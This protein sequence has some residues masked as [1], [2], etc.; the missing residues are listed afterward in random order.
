M[1]NWPAPEAWSRLYPGMQGQ[2]RVRLKGVATPDHPDDNCL[3]FVRSW[4]AESAR[5]LSGL[6]RALLLLPADRQGRHAELEAR[7]GVIYHEDPR[8]L[9]ACIAGRFF[10][11]QAHRG[12][13]RLQPESGVIMAEDVHVDPT[14]R[15]EPGVTICRG[16]RIGP[17]A[18]VLSG[19]RLGPEVTIGR[20]SVVRENAVLGG[21]GFGYAL[22][23]GRP[24]MRLPHLGGVILG[25]QVEVG[26][27]TTVCSGTIEPTRIEDRVK[28]DDH[29][30]IAHNC[31][32]QPDVMVTACAELS[33][34]VRVGGRSWLGPNCSV[35]NKI[36]IGPDC[37]IGL[38]AV[39]TE[40]VPERAT[41]TGNPARPLKQVLRERRALR[42]MLKDPSPPGS[43]RP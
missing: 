23:P 43:D 2:T 11:L 18:H 24:P 17:G 29:V 14:A 36:R 31:H 9:Y 21:F 41:V 16:C 8:Y 40:D 4:S 5:A 30:H 19:A 39:V 42:R 10:D 38:G 20:N 28:I 6:S 37:T 13:L 26:A 7:N 34:S 12:T 33:G 1:F 3:I 27:L 22:A 32:L 35:I 25:E 15:L